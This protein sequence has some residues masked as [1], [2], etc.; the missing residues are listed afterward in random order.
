ML[1]YAKQ[2]YHYT[3]VQQL[4]KH[5]Y[6]DFVHLQEGTLESEFKSKEDIGKLGDKPTTGDKQ[7]TRDKPPT[8]KKP[9]FEH[10]TLPPGDEPSTGDKP[11]TGPYQVI[12][13]SPSI[14]VIN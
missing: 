6:K 8:A 12:F 10:K 1:L 9:S 2:N 5:Y 11:L 14:Q 4:I 7:L 3:H 13:W